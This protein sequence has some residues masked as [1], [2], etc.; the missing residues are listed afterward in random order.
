MFYPNF[1]VNFIVWARDAFDIPP[2]Q[3]N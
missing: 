2:T 1:L 3:P